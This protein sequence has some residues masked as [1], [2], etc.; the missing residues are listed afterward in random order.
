MRPPR[1]L[2]ITWRV[3]F[4]EELRS[5]GYSRVTFALEPMGAVVKLTAVHDEVKPGS[6]V[7][8]GASEGWRMILDS[9]KSLLETG[10]PLPITSAGAAREAEAAAARSTAG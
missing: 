2:S 7:V 5:E 4:A 10:E 6:K 3:E 1:R 8:E 9:L